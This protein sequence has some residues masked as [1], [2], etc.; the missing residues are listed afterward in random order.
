MRKRGL[1]Q[2]KFSK[3]LKVNLFNWFLRF[4]YTRM[5]YNMSYRSRIQEQQILAEHIPRRYNHSVWQLQLQHENRVCQS[6]LPWSWPITH[7][8]FTFRKRWVLWAII[9]L[10]SINCIYNLPNIVWMS[11][12]C[13][14]RLVDISTA[15][16]LRYLYAN[17]KLWR[18]A[19]VGSLTYFE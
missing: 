14:T 16:I 11:W 2:T 19:Q 1:N 10:W 12:S 5:S 7:Q 18:N 3:S 9:S 15:G 17:H 6:Q 13:C 4:S 8:L